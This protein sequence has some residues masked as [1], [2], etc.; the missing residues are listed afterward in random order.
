MAT[1]V[2]GYYFAEQAQFLAEHGRFRSFE[3]SIVVLLFAAIQRILGD[4]VLA[5]K[6]GVS[7]LAGLAAP[8]G[9]LYGINSTGRIKT[10][11]LL[12]SLLAVSPCL[13]SL[14][15]HFPKTAGATAFLFAALAALESSFL[16][17]NPNKKARALSGILF[18]ALAFAHKL[19]FLIGAWVAVGTVI[20]HSAERISFHWRTSLFGLLLFV[21]FLA[22]GKVFLPTDLMRVFPALTWPQGWPLTLL[23]KRVF[24]PPALQTE[25]VL[26]LLALIPGLWLLKTLPHSRYRTLAWLLLIPA[27]F[28]PFLNNNVL[29]LSY[30]LIL[31]VFCREPSSGPGEFLPDGDISYGDWGFRPFWGFSPKRSMTH[32][33]TKP[34]PELTNTS[35]I[36]CRRT[37]SHWSFATWD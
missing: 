5:V 17:D 13:S 7:L 16:K 6:I 15:A 37:T 32:A 25:I 30:R 9:L 29:D 12:G 14:S 34:T 22:I 1:G 28:S 11:I 35:L 18:V 2:D 19:L 31:T 20:D 27:L 24:L 8:M 26:S 21:S 36:G 3:N 4:P 33:S 23:G 10:G